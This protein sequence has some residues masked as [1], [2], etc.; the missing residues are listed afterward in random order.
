MRQQ[1]PLS[2]GK[3][4]HRLIGDRLAGVALAAVAAA[5]LPQAAGAQETP[6]VADATITPA[7]VEEGSDSPIIVVSARNREEQLKDV[8]IPISVIRRIVKA[9]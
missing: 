5:A 6:E 2:G 4:R 1:S 9:C 8:P 3:R 7:A